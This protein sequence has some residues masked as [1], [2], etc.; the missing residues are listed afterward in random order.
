MS[1][2]NNSIEGEYRGLGS[3]YFIDKGR[4]ERFLYVN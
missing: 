3:I 2:I 4:I 1:L